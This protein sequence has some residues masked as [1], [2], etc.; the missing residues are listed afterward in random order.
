MNTYIKLIT[1][2][3]VLNELSEELS[4]ESLPTIH[5]AL[6]PNTELIKVTVDS[7][8]PQV[9][10]SVANTLANILI[11]RGIDLYSGG[12]KSVVEILSEQ[13]TNAEEELQNARQ[14]YDDI[15]FETW[16]GYRYCFL[17]GSNCPDQ[18]KEL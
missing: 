11:T 13:L 6:I 12:E 15:F 9:A 3:S 16:F 7:Q 8:N 2:T 1:S 17:I 14:N 10:Q 18:R 5:V 4:I